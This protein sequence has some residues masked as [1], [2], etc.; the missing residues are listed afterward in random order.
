MNAA[1]VMQARYDYDPYGRVTI[2]SGNLTADFGYSGMYYHAPSG[3]SLTLYRAYNADSGRW[4][5]RD[6]MLESGGLNLYDYV[7]NK[8]ISEVDYYG[9]QPVEDLE[10]EPNSRTYYEDSWTFMRN[11][12]PLAQATGL[13]GQLDDNV[14]VFD[15]DGN[16]TGEISLNPSS[17]GSIPQLP[18]NYQYQYA[19]TQL[20]LV[21][22]ILIFIMLYIHRLLKPNFAI[23]RHTQSAK[24]L[25]Q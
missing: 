12:S 9:L 20:V 13:M 1:G 7:S 8:P 3:L 25:R 22:D 16:E 2:V 14:G 24:I 6:P 11:P 19:W 21:M 5:S 15:N 23:V 10:P 17:D 18:P 4:L